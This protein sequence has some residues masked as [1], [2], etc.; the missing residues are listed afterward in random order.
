MKSIVRGAMRI[1]V[2]EEEDGTVEAEVEVGHT[3]KTV[4]HTP[5]ITTRR[6][7]VQS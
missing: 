3:T 1:P 4:R 2:V 7:I 6:R 5:K